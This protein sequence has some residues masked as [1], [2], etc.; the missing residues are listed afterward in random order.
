MKKNP[1]RSKTLW[2]NALVAA[3]GAVEA[4]AP[5]TLPAGPT[6]VAISVAGA[7]LRALTVTP[8]R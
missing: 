4:A 8:V 2:F 3:L 5:G 1:F 6:L 7:F